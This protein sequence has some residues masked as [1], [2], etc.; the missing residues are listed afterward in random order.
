[1]VRPSS[2]R[3]GVN[4]SL[5]RLSR[6]WRPCGE[7]PTDCA[8]A[9]PWPTP[10]NLQHTAYI[11]HTASSPQTGQLPHPGL[12]PT[13]YSIHTTY[14]IHTAY[15]QQPTAHRRGRCRTLACTLQ[16]TAYMQPTDSSLQLTDTAAVT[17]WPTAY[18]P[19]HSLQPTAYSLQTQQ[20]PHPG[21]RPRVLALRD[22]GHDL[23]VAAPLEIIHHDLDAWGRTQPSSLRRLTFHREAPVAAVFEGHVGPVDDYRPEPTATPAGGGLATSAGGSLATLFAGGLA[24]LSR[25]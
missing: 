5:P 14:N 22:E 9:T 25:R 17:P 4:T 3:L 20:L 11:Q 23:L 21:R 10:Y 12:H 8:A 18:I 13:T 6:S 15:N 7:Q 24:T 1:M 19:Q 2:R 16:P